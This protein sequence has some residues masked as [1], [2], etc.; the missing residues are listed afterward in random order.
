[1]YCARNLQLR[2]A[3]EVEFNKKVGEIGA[4]IL[5]SR[6]EDYMPFN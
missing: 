6:T 1:M 3:S 5:A 4:F 2:V